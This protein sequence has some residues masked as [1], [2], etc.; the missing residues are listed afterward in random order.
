[1]TRAYTRRKKNLVD[2]EI[3]FGFAWIVFAYLIL[4][5]FFLVITFGVPLW[6]ISHY[7]PGTDTDKLIAIGQF[8]MEGRLFW[9]LLAVFVVMVTLHSIVVTRKFA[10]PIFVMRRHLKRAQNGELSKIHL[11]RTDYLHD[12]SE[13][14]NEHFDQL[15]GMLI[16]IQTS[17]QTIKT[18]LDQMESLEAN[19]TDTSKTNID[20]V[21]SELEKLQQ[22]TAQCWH[23]G[24]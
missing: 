17:V 9:F 21:K 7:T 2:R 15:K 24:D 19:G 11:R 6:W 3:Q 4:Y 22:I 20:D 13:L 1:M 16:E 5:T 12:I 14:L 10:G 23:H 8:V 18:S